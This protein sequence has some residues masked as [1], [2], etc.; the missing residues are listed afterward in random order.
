MFDSPSMPI[1]FYGTDNEMITPKRNVCQ[2]W[3]YWFS[4]VG[5][6]ISSEIKIVSRRCVL[7]DFWFS[8]INSRDLENK[9]QCFLWYFF[10]QNV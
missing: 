10:Q 9:P 7:Y 5:N 2:H 3:N 8:G 6:V 4:S 1:D